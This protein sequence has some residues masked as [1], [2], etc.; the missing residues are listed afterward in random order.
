MDF[1]PGPIQT[2]PFYQVTA[3][4]EFCS[5][6]W[7]YQ[8]CEMDFSNSLH[9]FVKLINGFFQVVT[10]ISLICHIDLSKFISSSCH[11]DLSKLVY[12]DF[13]KWLYGF[14]KVLNGFL[15][16]L[17]GFFKVFYACLA[18]VPNKT[19]LKCDQDLLAYWR[20]CFEL[21]VLNESK[22][23]MPRVCCAFGN[24]CNTNSLCLIIFLLWTQQV[25]KYL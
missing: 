12:T 21:K 19:K 13:S 8:N 3:L 25:G 2:T 17:H 9:G 6:C 11:M 5:N 22:Y 20:F 4:V 23:S 10:W 1:S 14:V 15:K 18:L 16:L 24:V 7:I